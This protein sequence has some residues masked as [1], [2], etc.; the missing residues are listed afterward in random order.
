V[1]P[2]DTHEPLSPGLVASIPI[3]SITTSRRNPRQRLR[4]VDELA[5]SLLMYGLLQPI[6]VRRKGKRYEVIAGHRRLAAARQ[7]GWQSIDASVRTESVDDAFLLT[8][9][10]NLQ[11]QDLSPREEAEALGTLV[12]E[13][14][15]STRQIAS[16][17]H[18]SQAFVSKRVRVFDDKLLAPAVLDGRL[19]VSAA[20]ELLAV[21]E[22]RRYDLLARAIDE[23]W[24]F[25]QLRAA[26]RDSLESR[27][28]AVRSRTILG[29][30]VSELRREL[31]S[32][33][34]EELS[35]ADRRALQRL[36]DELEMLTAPSSGARG[37]PQP[38]PH[39]PAA[40]APK[41]LRPRHGHRS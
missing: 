28:A 17:I 20:E 22:Q 5:A 31:R 6:V 29:Q 30:R 15:W 35:G 34:L 3:A 11:R 7:L 33:T 36:L 14:G 40:E 4:G 23:S 39:P 32:L 21:P 41:P 38:Q 18:R 2:P 13:R 16:A 37:Q 1:D 25:G 8:L 24:D 12:K 19:S 27:P 26:I 9:V 10:E